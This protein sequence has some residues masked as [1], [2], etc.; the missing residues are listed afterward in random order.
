M[1]EK[2]ITCLLW[3]GVVL[4]ASVVIY[5]FFEVVYLNVTGDYWLL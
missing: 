5:A 1:K 2:L 4:S 3:T